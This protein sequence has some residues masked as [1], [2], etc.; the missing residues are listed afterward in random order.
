MLQLYLQ[1]YRLASGLHFSISQFCWEHYVTTIFLCKLLSVSISLCGSLFI[2]SFSLFHLAS[3]SVISARSEKPQSVSMLFACRLG[4][5]K[6]DDHS[7]C[8]RWCIGCAAINA[9]QPPVSPS[10][11]PFLLMSDCSWCFLMKHIQADK[12][13]TGLQMKAAIVTLQRSNL[14]TTSLFIFLLFRSL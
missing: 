9:H 13:A 3:W 11:S 8:W 7:E 12:T 10:S 1:P 5:I 6:E 14:I 4:Y 2:L